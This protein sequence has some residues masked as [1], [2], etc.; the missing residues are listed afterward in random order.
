[1]L[2]KS[3]LADEPNF[4]GPLMR[5]T[6][7][8]VRDQIDL[9]KRNHESRNGLKEP[10]SG[11]ETEQSTFAR[12]LEPFDF[13]LFQQYLPRSDIAWPRVAQSLYPNIFRCY[14]SVTDF[15][16]CLW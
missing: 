15:G 9:H 6:R 7:G 12:F 5:S 14:P 16:C 1:V 2:K 8:D 4:S 10:R 13:R 3:F 11:G